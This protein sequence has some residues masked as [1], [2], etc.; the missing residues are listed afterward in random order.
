MAAR[1]A[2]ARRSFISRC[3][4]AVLRRLC[5][6]SRGHRDKPG[7][8]LTPAAPKRRNGTTGH[9]ERLAGFAAA[10]EELSIKADNERERLSEVFGYYAGVTFVI[11]VRRGVVNAGVSWVAFGDVTGVVDVRE[12]L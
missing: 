6:H 8:A 12:H 10:A 3:Y 4:A 7:A 1:E 5:F 9:D 2:H 11:R